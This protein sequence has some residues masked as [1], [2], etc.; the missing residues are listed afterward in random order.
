MAPGDKT[1]KVIIQYDK[2]VMSTYNRVPIVLTKGSGCRVWDIEG[3]EYLDFFPG[4]AVSGLGHCHTRVVRAIRRQANKMLHISNNYYNHL[5]AKL[6]RELINASF[7]G[8]AFFCNSGAEANEGAIKFARKFGN[9]AR[10]EI[11]TMENS[12]HGRTLA[13][14]TATGQP[15]YQEGFEP[16]PAGFKHVPFNDLTAVKNAVTDKTIAIMVE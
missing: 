3:K 14:I 5:Q 2:Y 16:L 4:W 10:Y 8:K 11:I 1:R 15:K 13:T 6:A 7:D 9:P 12:F